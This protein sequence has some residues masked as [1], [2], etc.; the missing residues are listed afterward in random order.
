MVE[1]AW[2]TFPDY[3]EQLLDLVP[4]AERVAV[5]LLITGTQAGAWG[6]L[7]PTGR[8]LQFE[9][10]L[11][12]TFDAS[13]RVTHQRGITDNLSGL[14]RAGVIPTPRDHER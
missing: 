4:E 7:P 9:E 1:R 6:P 11:F 14:R 3:H 2:T 12:F 10:M 5:H 8:R 13:G